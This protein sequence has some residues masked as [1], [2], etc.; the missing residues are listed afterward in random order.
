MRKIE[1]FKAAFIMSVMSMLMPAESFAE[2]TW[3]GSVD[4]NPIIST[5]KGEDASLNINLSAIRKVSDYAGLGFGFG[6]NESFKFK[7]APSVPVFVRFHSE[8]FSRETSP[9]L[10]VDAGYSFSIEDFDNSGFII[11]PTV[12]FRYK[13]LSLGVGYYGSK[14]QASGSKFTSAINIRLAY[15]FGYHKS[16]SGFAEGLR[17]CEFGVSL[18]TLVPLSGTE[19]FS[20]DIAYGYSSGA[21]LDL[22]FLYPVTEK[23]YLGLAAGIGY[24]NTKEYDNRYSFYEYYKEKRGR[25][26]LALRG[27]YK[28]KQLTFRERFYPYVQLDLGGC[29]DLAEDFDFYTSPEIG[30]SMDIAG[31]A[32]SLDLGIGYTM[33]KKDKYE[34]SRSDYDVSENAGCL[35]ISLGYTF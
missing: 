30:I 22:S 11:N 3:R 33:V 26:F 5:E 19:A 15:T 34:V 20:N 14:S 1:I 12:G 21:D 28:A 2:D 23:V 29:F 4:V 8:E 25:L 10:T 9:F 31:G 24:I 18:G 27:K 32:H 6:V 35:R 17:K 16:Y 7:T 13:A